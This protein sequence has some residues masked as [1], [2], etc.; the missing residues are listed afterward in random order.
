MTEVQSVL[1]SSDEPTLAIL[2]NA[3]LSVMDF[4]LAAMKKKEKIYFH[5]NVQSKQEKQDNYSR[6]SKFG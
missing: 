4:S 6:C 1:L 5:H 2:P 3:R